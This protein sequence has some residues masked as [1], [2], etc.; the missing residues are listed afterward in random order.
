MMKHEN[1]KEIYRS[2]NKHEET[3]NHKRKIVNGV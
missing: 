3:T 1:H 2:L